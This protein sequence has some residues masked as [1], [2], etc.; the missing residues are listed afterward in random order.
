MWKK[1]FSNL[2][3]EY[4]IWNVSEY[5]YSPEIFD[6]NVLDYSKPAYPNPALH[7]LFILCEEMTRW[8]DRDPNNLLFIHCQKSFS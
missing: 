8:L 3:G 6:N 4:K 7:E 2:K 1:K 5:S